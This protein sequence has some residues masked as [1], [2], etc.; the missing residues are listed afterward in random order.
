MQERVKLKNKEKVQA[1]KE[2]L[3]SPR[4]K[5]FFTAEELT[6]GLLYFLNSKVISASMQDKL[7]DA[8]YN[9]INNA[10]GCIIISSEPTYN[11]KYSDRIESLISYTEQRLLDMGINGVDDVADNLSIYLKDDD[12]NESTLIYGTSERLYKV[13]VEVKGDNLIPSLIL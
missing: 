6:D 12:S 5:P 8:I 3:D 10:R 9:H 7:P 1:L 13:I 2:F 4:N 11:S